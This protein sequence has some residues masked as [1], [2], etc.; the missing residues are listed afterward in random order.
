MPVPQLHVVALHFTFAWLSA[1]RVGCEC[2]CESGAE[3]IGEALQ[4]QTAARVTPCSCST[5][6]LLFLV[7][8]LVFGSVFG[9]CVTFALLAR[10][11]VTTKAVSNGAGV[12]EEGFGA[13]CQ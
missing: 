3:A 13:H 2:H 9:I 7:V 11:R 10:A 8:G 1:P 5:E 4:Q 12:E 6:S